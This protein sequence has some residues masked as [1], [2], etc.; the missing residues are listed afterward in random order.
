MLSHYWGRAL[1]REWWWVS[2]N[3]FDRAGVAVECMVLHSGVWGVPLGIR[4]GYL[5]LEHD[6]QT[7]LWIAPP[8]WIQAAGT[9]ESFEIRLWAPGRKPVRLV[10]R[11][12]DYGN[13]GERIANTLTGDLDVWEGERVIARAVRTAGLERRGPPGV[14]P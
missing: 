13:F 11:G 14:S 1:P 10:A 12:R 8:A 5:H 6:G 7:R 9:P 3:Q 4:L 2:A